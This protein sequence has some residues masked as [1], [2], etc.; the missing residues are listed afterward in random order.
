MERFVPTVYKHTQTAASALWTITHNL[1]RYPVVD[2]FITVDGQLRKVMPAE[3]TFIDSNTC[4]VAFTSP[5][6]GFAT[7]A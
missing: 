1:G 4:T 3:V 7:V 5:R 6:A 2:T